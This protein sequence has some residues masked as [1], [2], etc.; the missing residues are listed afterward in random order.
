MKKISLVFLLISLVC[1]SFAQTPLTALEQPSKAKL[2]EQ[3]INNPN[4][5]V[6]PGILVYSQPF[7][8]P[9]VNGFAIA[10]GIYEVADDFSLTSSSTIDFIRLW[11]WMN[12]DPANTSWI[13][14]IYSNQSCLPSALIGTWYI[15]ALDM[16]YEYV[17]NAYGYP[18][19]DLSAN[20]TPAFI[21][22]PNVYYWISISPISG[23]ND[24]WNSY[25]NAGDYL[26]CQAVFKSPL[27]DIPNFVPIGPFVGYPFDFTFELYSTG[28]VPSEIPVSNWAIGLGIFLILSAAVLRFR[29]II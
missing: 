13:V 19:Y 29:R 9:P 4:R 6:P 7:V 5:N 3:A 8:C 18:I 2:P 1:I 27:Y 11:S 16:N 12:D 23:S 21:A 15:A 22:D 17:C 28:T 24:Y 10:E 26:N 25:G 14:R 20:L